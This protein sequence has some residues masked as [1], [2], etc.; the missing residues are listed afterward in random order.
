MLL[1]NLQ[2]FDWK[3]LFVSFTVNMDALVTMLWPVL[4]IHCVFTLC[5]A[6]SDTRYENIDTI[7]PVVRSSPEL[8]QFS[9]DFFG[10]TVVL[11]STDLRHTVDNTL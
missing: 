11:H 9:D 3:V 7:Q 4:L 10:Y 6:Q 2:H 1:L 8:G 5:V